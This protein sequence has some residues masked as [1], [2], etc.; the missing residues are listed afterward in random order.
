MKRIIF[1]FLTVTIS[2]LSIAQNPNEHDAVIIGKYS[3][4]NNEIA[5]IQDQETS[6]SYKSEALT[7]GTLHTGDRI[8]IVC[9]AT[10]TEAEIIKD[11]LGNRTMCFNSTWNEGYNVA[12]HIDGEDQVLLGGSVREIPHGNG[13]MVI[14]EGGTMVLPGNASLINVWSQNGNGDNNNGGAPIVWE[15]YDGPKGH[16]SGTLETSDGLGIL[17]DGN[18]G[19]CFRQAAKAGVL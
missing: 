2:L 12:I 15:K 8:R 4:G 17:C 16:Y 6:I 10:Y 3:V 11:G 14:L 5:V 7:Q 18:R 9:N 13:T 19:K 1:T